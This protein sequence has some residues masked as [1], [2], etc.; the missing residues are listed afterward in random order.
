MIIIMPEYVTR[1]AK[2]MDKPK[3]LPILILATASN[4]ILMSVLLRQDIT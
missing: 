2:V 4:K 1:G 3:N